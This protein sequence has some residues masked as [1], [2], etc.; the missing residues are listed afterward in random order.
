MVRTEWVVRGVRLSWQCYADITRMAPASHSTKSEGVDVGS[1]M[2]RHSR[3]GGTH[4]A[5]SDGVSASMFTS[6]VS[7]V[8]TCFSIP[9]SASRS[10]RFCP[11]DL[12][13]NR[14]VCSKS[15]VACLQWIGSTTRRDEPGSA[16]CQ[17]EIACGGGSGS[18][19][20]LNL[21]A[22]RASD[23]GT[24]ALERGEW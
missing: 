11:N 14:T 3:M 8:V 13:F 16:A 19:T 17:L 2:P 7:S 4:R 23:T 21:E 12:T 15:S 5:S 20:V 18:G 10:L 9:L 22:R 1:R 24:P 6:L